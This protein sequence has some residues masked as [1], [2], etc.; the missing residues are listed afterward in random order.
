MAVFVIRIEERHQDID[1]R[2]KSVGFSIMSG[3]DGELEKGDCLPGI[4][5]LLLRAV[6]EAI[7]NVFGSPVALSD[8]SMEEA[9][10]MARANRFTH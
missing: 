10:A 3:Y 1:A 4:E 2:H 9:E 7:D 6:R 8:E 5:P